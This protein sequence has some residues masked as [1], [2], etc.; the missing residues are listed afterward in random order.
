[1]PSHTTIRRATSLT[2]SSLPRC[3]NT[4][5]K[6]LKRKIDLVG[7][8]ACL[9]N[10]VEVAYELRGGADFIVG[11][12]EVEPGDGWPYDRVLADLVAKPTM[13][14]EKLGAVIVKR[15][16]DS[17]K[18]DSVTQSLLD[19]AQAPATAQAVDKLA[20]ALIEALKD[21]EFGAIAKAAKDTQ[22]FDMKDFLDL[23]D[24]AAQLKKRC[25]SEAVKSAAQAVI[26]SLAGGLVA[27]RAP[28]R[29][30]CRP[31]LRCRHLL[32]RLGARSRA[33]L[34]TAGLRQGNA[35]GSVSARL[36]RRLTSGVHD[37]AVGR[38]WMGGDAGAR[39]PGRIVRPV[40]RQ[41]AK[42]MPR[43]ALMIP[44]TQNQG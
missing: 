21:G 15:Y 35:M 39:S 17:Y 14:A 3:S 37:P 44:L 29:E 22:R 34:R 11:S 32:S 41:A 10:M 42:L 9:M 26:D 24:L 38:W 23:G 13:S 2:I 19:L 20:V 5:K 8:D 31:L 36:R 1:M 12:E 6:K 18:G 43:L 4:V 30:R 16:V 7:F 25:A 28:H 40:H 33:G 27:S